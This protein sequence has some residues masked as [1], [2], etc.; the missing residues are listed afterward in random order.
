MIVQCTECMRIR[1]GGAFRLPWPGEVSGEVTEV[2]CPR[3]ARERLAR[4]Q[5]GEF[6]GVGGF[7]AARAVAQGGL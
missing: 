4:V 2:F 5:A 1:V 7:V 6:A 3:C